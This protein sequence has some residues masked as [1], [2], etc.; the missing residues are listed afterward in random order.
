MGGGIGYRKV[1]NTEIIAGKRLNGPYYQLA[2]K[3]YFGEIVRRV[4][5]KK[6]SKIK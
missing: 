4:F 6:D 3:I 5:S 1:L 2:V